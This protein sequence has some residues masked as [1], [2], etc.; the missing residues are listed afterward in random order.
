MIINIKL[1]SAK[2]EQPEILSSAVLFFFKLFIGVES[3]LLMK[4]ILEL[5]SMFGKVSKNNAELT[6][7][8]IIFL[9]IQEFQL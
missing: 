1:F 9:K 3:G 2:D 7:K 6:F 5:R 8:V 4:H